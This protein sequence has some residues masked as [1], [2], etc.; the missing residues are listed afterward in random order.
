MWTDLQVSSVLWCYQQPRMNLYTMLRARERY[1]AMA[2]P[3]LSQNIRDVSGLAQYEH[4]PKDDVWEGC[5]WKVHCARDIRGEVFV[6]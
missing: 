2:E 5:V 3:F 1:T 6:V 4:G